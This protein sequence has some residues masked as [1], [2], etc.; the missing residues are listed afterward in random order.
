[1]TKFKPKFVDFFVNDMMKD[2][3]KAK[4]REA[5]NKIEKMDFNYKVLSVFEE[6]VVHKINE[7]INKIN[8]K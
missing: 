4:K 1:M 2:L 7:I 8:S 6:D 3:A 5:K